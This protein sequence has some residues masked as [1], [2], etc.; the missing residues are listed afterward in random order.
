MFD[1]ITYN[2]EDGEDIGH[3]ITVYALSTCG[4]CRRGLAFLR[5]HNI[6]FRYIYVDKIEYE[7][8]RKIKALLREKFQKRVAFPYMVV[9]EEFVIVGFTEKEWVDKLG[10]GKEKKKKTIEDALMFQSMVAKKHGYKLNR[11]ESFLKM[12]AEGLVINYNRYGYY[13]CPCRDASG[14]KEK[15]KDIICPCEY[16][17]ADIKEYGHCYCGL[18]LS[19]EFY[20]SGKVPSSIPDRRPEEKYD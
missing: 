7:T 15:D 11:D 16:S 8:K 14:V 4:F 18:Y 2:E 20:E 9:D 5:D 13:S 3:D 1:F 10:I 17:E 19:E 6:K 12:L